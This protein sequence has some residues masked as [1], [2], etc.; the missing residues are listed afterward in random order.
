[1][2]DDADRRPRHFVVPLD[3]TP[4]STTAIP[5]ASQLAERLDASVTL[6]SAVDSV[7]EEP[8]RVAWLESLE[9][10]KRRVEYDVV[11]NRDPAGAIHETLRGLPCSIACMASHAR[12]RMAAM[13]RSVLTEL[14][15][16]GHD[17]VIAV[18]P[19]RGDFA[20]STEHQPLRGVVVGVDDN[21]EAAHL[22]EVAADWSA[23][24]REPLAVLTVAEPVPPQ[25]VSG[26]VRR[27]YGPDDVDGFL[28]TLLARAR[29]DAVELEPRVLYNP[30]SPVNGIISW[31]YEHPTVLVIV[32]TAA[33][34]GL[35][36]LAKGSTAA[37]ITRESAAPVLVVP[38]RVVRTQLGS[39]STT[40]R[41]KQPAR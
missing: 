10:V 36:R 25:V 1:M 14:L 6:F 17:Q 39:S 21:A 35:E 7:D 27:R 40:R 33:P 9:V 24:L 15:V 8:G 23:Q 2:T 41:T 31:V 29:L 20:P 28:R 16:R 5:T 4:F 37:A 11:V 26:P 3:G 13:T 32:G 22:L 18:G 12:V 19:G 30:I 38:T 34:T